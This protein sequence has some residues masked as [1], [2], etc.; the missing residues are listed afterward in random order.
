M[1]TPQLDAPDTSSPSLHE[2]PAASKAL[3]SVLA[4]IFH[5]QEHFC[6]KTCFFVEILQK[7]NFY[8]KLGPIGLKVC[9]GLKVI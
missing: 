6:M 2:A 9:T 1:E 8:F 4:G 7:G 5:Y 3:E